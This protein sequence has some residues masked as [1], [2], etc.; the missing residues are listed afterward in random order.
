MPIETIKCQECGSADVTEFKPGSY[1]CSH[2]ESVFKVVST[3]GAG[4]SDGTW[5]EDHRTHNGRCR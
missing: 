4:V 5:G 1:V 3:V 2:C